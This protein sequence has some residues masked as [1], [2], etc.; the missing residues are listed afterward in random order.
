[1]IT[2]D[3]IQRDF[4]SLAGKCYLNTAAEGIPPTA[5][6]AG[7]QE[8]WKDKLLGMDGR[9]KHFAIEAR[10]KQRAGQLLGLSPDEIGFCSCSAEAYNLLAGALR[11]AETDE[12]VVSDIDFP[13]GFTPW[14]GK[15]RLR[16]WKNREGALEMADLAAILSPRVR[17]VQVS[18]VSFYNG[19]RLPWEE[20]ITLVRRLAPEATVSVDVTQALG[21]CVLNCTGADIII[22]STHKWLLGI[23]GGCVVGIPQ[24]AAERLTTS[25][26]GWYHIRNAFDSDRFERSI[27]KS[28]AASYS[29]GMP[30]FAPIY[31]LDAAMAYLL[32]LGVEHIARYADPLVQAAFDGIQSLGLSPLAPLTSS[33]I[34][35][36]K[37]PQGERLNHHLRSRGIHIMHQA[38]RLRASFH[39]YN[40]DRDVRLFL[41]TL[42]AALKQ[43]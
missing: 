26:G 9:E 20:F 27:R 14:I 13:S 23:H 22:S 8:Y 32:A 42:S 11:P 28:G 33:G 35:A 43:S 31:A 2:T 7:L 39:A 17:L 24:P 19:W 40:T 4:P 6:G 29:V 10:A 34:I 12:V 41:E 15:S 36:F 21:R 16:V 30:S 37:H 25:A 3:A 5:V 38:G 18:L 1:M